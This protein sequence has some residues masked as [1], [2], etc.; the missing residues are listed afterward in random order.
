VR[1]DIVMRLL[2]GAQ[3][4][5]VL[6]EDCRRYTELLQSRGVDAVLTIE[7]GLGHNLLVTPATFRELGILIRSMKE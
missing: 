3:D 7:S 4:D 5:V 6:P 1:P 2:V